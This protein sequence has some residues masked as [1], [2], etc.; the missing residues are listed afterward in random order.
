MICYVFWLFDATQLYMPF[1]LSTYLAE[2][3]LMAVVPL[4]L[5]SLAVSTPDYL[6]NC[7]GHF[8]VVD[9]PNWLF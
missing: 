4:Q 6:A 5:N 3:W 9:M 8:G 2:M 7:N 1:M